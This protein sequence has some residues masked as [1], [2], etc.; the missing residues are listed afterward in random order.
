MIFPLAVSLPIDISIHMLNPVAFA[1]KCR[2]SAAR[3][4]AHRGALTSAVIRL[5]AFQ[6]SPRSNRVTDSKRFLDFHAAVRHP[7]DYQLLFASELLLENS[8]AS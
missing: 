3:A 7:G 1:S 8:R 4:K 5:T 2:D 6:R